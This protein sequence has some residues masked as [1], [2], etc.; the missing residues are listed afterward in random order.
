MIAVNLTE[1]Q[2]AA[3]AGASDEVV[4]RG[5]TGDIIGYLCRVSPDDLP[6]LTPDEIATIKRRMAD[7]IEKTITAAEVRDRL[8]VLAEKRATGQV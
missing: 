1:S 6:V 8:D 7:P 4:V 3:I 5:P 2:V